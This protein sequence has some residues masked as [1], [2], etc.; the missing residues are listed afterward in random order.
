MQAVDVVWVRHDLRLT[1][2]PALTACKERPLVL[3]FTADGIDLESIGAASRVYLHHALTSFQND[4]RKVYGARLLIFSTLDEALETIQRTVRVDQVLWNR[5][6]DPTRFERD[7]AWEDRLKAQGMRPIVCRGSVL[8]EPWEIKNKSGKPFKVFTPFYKTFLARG[9][10]LEPVARPRQLKTFEHPKLHEGQVESL[11][12]LPPKPRWDLPMMSSWIT[13]E[14]EWW[15]AWKSFR[16]RRLLQYPQARDVPSETGTSRISAALHFGQISPRS[17]WADARK[18]PDAGTESFLRQVVWREFAISSLFYQPT[19]DRVPIIQPF[20]KFPWAD[21][22]EHLLAW[23]RGRTGY[24]IVDAG[25]RELWQTGWMHNRVRLIVGSFLVKNLHINWVEGWNFFWDTLVDADR[26][27]NSMGWQ[28]VAGCGI[29][30][31]PYFRIFNPM[32]Q[33]ERFDPDGTYIKR[34]IPELE[35]IPKRWIHSPW[36]APPATRRLAADYPDPVVDFAESRQ[37]ALMF[38]DK[39]KRIKAAA[40]R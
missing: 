13:S 17:L 11:H 40:H 6:Y 20:E 12:L 35:R 25:M 3:I 29:D 39:I 33:S 27:N 4:L 10:P 1:D 23:Q 28:W 24:P 30:P 22:P 14:S 7:S 15:Q 38:Y 8:V 32:V 34:W 36:K 16:Q 18:H 2:N 37:Q 19:M 21:E 26:A 9:A 31:S 5:A